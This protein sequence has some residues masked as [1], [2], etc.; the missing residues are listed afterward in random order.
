MT[1][2]HLVVYGIPN[3]IRLLD[4]EDIM[5]EKFDWT[6]GLQWIL[7]S[8][9]GF[10]LM[11]MLALATIW[12]VGSSV[13]KELGPWLG[14]AASGALLGAL[15]ALGVSGGS[16]LLLRGKGVAAAHWIG[17]SVVAGV[18]SGIIGFTAAMILAESQTIADWVLA[19]VASLPLGLSIGIGQKLALGQA[20]SK[21]NA[22]PII[23]ALAFATLALTVGEPIINESPYW[24]WLGTTGL[25]YGA[26]SG[27]GMIWIMHRHPALAQ[28]TG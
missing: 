7:V 14:S 4:T 18:L 1:T 10:A 11:F 3:P 19:L 15:F 17:Y 6:F 21:A 28:G 26:V 22:W 5:N 25:L 20:G 2:G 24:L 13:E 16:S 23:S 27:L 12:Q 9:L 8:G